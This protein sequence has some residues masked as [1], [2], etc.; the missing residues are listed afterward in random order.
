GVS[1]PPVVG[2][3]LI[4]FVADDGEATAITRRGE[5]VWSRGV[6]IDREVVTNK[7]ARVGRF[8]TPPILVRDAVLTGSND[9]WLYALEA[10][11]GKTRWKYKVGESLNG[12][13]NWIEREGERGDS[14]VVISQEEGS[15]HRVDLATGNAIWV[16]RSAARSDGSPG[17]GRSFVAFGGCDAALHFLSISNG[18]VLG[19]VGLESDGQVAGGVAVSGD[20]VFAGTR[21]GM[22][23]CADAMKNIILWTNQTAKGEAFATPAVTSNRIVV[24]S[25]DGFVY[26]LDRIDGR[27]LW[28]FRTGDNV[29]SPAVAGDKV[30][31][32]SGGTIF[33]LKLK[34]GSKLWDSKAGD[35]VS[36][37]AVV[38]GGLIIGTDDGFVIMYG[39]AINPS[40]AR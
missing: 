19:S 22:I 31:V 9:G 26:C 10:S 2:S 40:P 36:S 8:A 37:P 11:S 32:S 6:G 5:K 38:E 35:L 15:V 12:T 39:D 16:S 18:E 29:L 30:V 7:M 23:V 33:V 24:G 3:N 20:Q 27:T 13:A 28:S 34:D 21:G 17:V 1:I 25:N 4:V 14:I